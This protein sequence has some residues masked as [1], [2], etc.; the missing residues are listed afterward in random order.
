[1]KKT[2]LLAA[3][4]ACTGVAQAEQFVCTAHVFTVLTLDPET[5]EWRGNSASPK[6][7]DPMQI[8]VD[9]E[10][11]MYS[12]DTG[13]YEGNCKVGTSYIRCIDTLLKTRTIFMH[14][15]F[16]DEDKLF[17]YSVSWVAENASYA[18]SCIKL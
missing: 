3:A 1:M 8:R 11:G 10:K 16:I 15:G 4:L 7:S 17:T 14:D 12:P 9:T 18:G 6:A 5:A 2:L 13:R